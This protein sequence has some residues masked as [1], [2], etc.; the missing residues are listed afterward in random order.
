[1][2]VYQGA[3][4][5]MGYVGGA[6]TSFWDAAT[7]SRDREILDAKPKDAKW[8]HTKWSRD[9]LTAYARIIY[10]NVGFAKGAV[11]DIARVADVARRHGIFLHV[12]DAPTPTLANAP[13]VAAITRPHNAVVECAEPTNANRVRSSKEGERDMMI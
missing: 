1:M 4:R 2:M 11:D 3:G 8:T 6:A 9:I 13:S 12:A 10:T 7:P 5:L